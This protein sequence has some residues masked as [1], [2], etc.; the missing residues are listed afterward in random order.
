VEYPA[1]T[2]GKNGVYVAFNIFE[3]FAET[4]PCEIRRVLISVID[5]LLGERL[6][7]SNLPTQA[8]CTLREQKQNNRY[9]LQVLYGIPYSA[10]FGV[11]VIDDIPTLYNSE[12]SVVVDKR[13]K[14]V[15]DKD[16]NA[17]AF[18]QIGNKVKFKVE[19]IYAHEIISIEY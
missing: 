17:I 4:A 13:A 8:I 12:Y 15:K 11:C 19:K 10:G 9:I 2:Q 6:V 16:G 14:A 5:G 1:I 3:E 7:S 18:E